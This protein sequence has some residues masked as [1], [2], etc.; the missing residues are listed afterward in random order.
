MNLKKIVFI[1]SLI[2]LVASC[3]K[4]HSDSDDF[5]PGEV[6][7]GINSG[8]E[9]TELFTFI[10][11]F[12]HKVDN[13]N[14]LTFVSDLPSDSL[15]YVLTFLNDKTYTNDRTRWFVTG[16]LHSQTSQIT[17]FPRLFGI[18]NLEY[19][20]DWLISMDSL[21]LKEQHNAGLNS[22]IILFNV[23]D[24]QERK[25]K[26]EFEKFEIVDWADLNYLGGIEPHM[27]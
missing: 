1:I 19:Q 21:A 15:Q 3:S 10:N 14:S 24:G 20:S 8:T 7:V 22:G 27:D 16:Y 23:P 4:D 17:I 26:R 12:D 6:I 5:V 25:W 9:I 18:E 11:R 13:V 2:G